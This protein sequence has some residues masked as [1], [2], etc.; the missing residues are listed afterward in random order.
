MPELPE[1]ETTRKGIAPYVVGKR[2]TDVIIRER[3]LRWPIPAGLKRSL[4]NKAIRKLRRRAKYLLFYTD[5]GCLLLHLGMSGSLRIID[6][7][8]PPAK[9]DHVDIVFASGRALRF[10]DPRRFGSMLWTKGDPMDHKLLNQLGPE[11]LSDAFVADYLYARSRKRTQAIKTFIIDSRIVVGVGNIY[12]SESL[13]LARIN[14]NRKAG[15]IS[16]ARYGTL[17]VAIKDVLNRAIEKGGTTLRDFINSDGQPGY[18]K[19]ELQVYGRGGEPCNNC[20]RPIKVARL[21]QRST[22]YCASC[23]T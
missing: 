11:P 20:Q 19:N 16:K 15:T 10:H 2:V 3:R 4:K 17:I 23:Q 21:G 13:F 14:P 18:F 12:A 5:N 6:N 22:F 9:H 8:W 1:I 7:K